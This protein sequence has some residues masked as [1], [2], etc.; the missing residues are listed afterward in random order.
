VD[1]AKAQRGDVESFLNDAGRDGAP[2]YFIRD[3]VNRLTSPDLRRF[4]PTSFA[5]AA[6]RP[7]GKQCGRFGWI[8][9]E[10][11]PS[12]A[13][14]RP[15]FHRLCTKVRRMLDYALKQY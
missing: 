2:K 1:C 13:N 12:R 15:R 14:C 11:Q 9:A 5:E 8:T 3:Y 4:A 10:V 6:R 7:S